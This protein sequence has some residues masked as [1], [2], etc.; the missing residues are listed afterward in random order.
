MVP[1]GA[2]DRKTQRRV[3]AGSPT[4]QSGVLSPADEPARVQTPAEAG[5]ADQGSAGRS[6]HSR[7][8]MRSAISVGAP[9]ADA[10][11]PRP[12]SMPSA[13]GDARRG[14]ARSQTSFRALDLVEPTG[15]WITEKE[16]E[17]VRA[18]SGSAPPVEG[19]KLARIQRDP[20]ACTH[21]E[22]PH[23]RGAVWKTVPPAVQVRLLVSRSHQ[24]HGDVAQPAA[25]RWQRRRRRFAPAVSTSPSRLPL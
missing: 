24:P 3:A 13:A 11:G 17:A 23:R 19:F 6:K 9:R 22:T 2:V 15:I 8:G 10:R 16:H 20:S 5:I 4:D 1:L 18:L 12:L 25:R 21:A 14:M 7:R